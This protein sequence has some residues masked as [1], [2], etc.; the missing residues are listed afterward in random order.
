MSRA[1]TAYAMSDRERQ[2][3][4]QVED[5]SDLQ[6]VSEIWAVVA[7]RHGSIVALRDPQAKP[8]VTL[9]YAQLHQQMQQFAA[10]LQVLGIQPGSNPLA[11]F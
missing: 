11:V 5:H 1:V 10:G 8:E 2:N 9:T 4:S 3:L 7:Q 6:A